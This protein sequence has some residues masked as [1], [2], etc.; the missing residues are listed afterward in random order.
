MPSRVIIFTLFIKLQT[1]YNLNVTHRQM[2]KLI[3]VHTYKEQISYV[4]E[5]YMKREQFQRHMKK[6]SHM[7]IMFYIITEMVIICMYTY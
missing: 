6:L 3:V 2:D 1:G 4:L 7:M 5:L